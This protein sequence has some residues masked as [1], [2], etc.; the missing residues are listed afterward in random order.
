MKKRFGS[1]IA[2]ALSAAL[3]FA[4]VFSA[5]A[6]ESG[7]DGA[8]GET[9]TGETINA[10]TESPE[11]APVIEKVET[12]QAAKEAARGSVSGDSKVTWTNNTMPACFDITT[13][14]LWRR[15]FLTSV[16][17]VSIKEKT[18]II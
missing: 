11:V 2:M 9:I 16:G 18:P 15:A 8:A 5:Q 1:V 14:N 3:C 4:S 6:A 10:E 7:G 12:E 17:A 13:S